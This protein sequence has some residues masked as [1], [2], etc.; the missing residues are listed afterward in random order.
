MSLGIRHLWAW[1]AHSNGIINILP[2]TP[3][4]SVSESL[5][6]CDTEHEVYE[7]LQHRRQR[8]VEY[9]AA[10][11]YADAL[12]MLMGFKKPIDRFFVDVLVMAEDPAVRT[13]RLALLSQFYLVFHQ[14]ADFSQVVIEA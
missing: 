8:I 1:S 3:P 2:E 14:F 5:F 9:L 4:T 13:N 11:K 10:R 7:Q 6:A 12:A